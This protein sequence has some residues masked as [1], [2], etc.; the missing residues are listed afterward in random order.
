M[1]VV[2]GCSGSGKSRYL[3]EALLCER[4]ALD[5]HGRHLIVSWICDPQEGQ[6]LPDWQDRVD[7]FA[8]GPVEGL[9]ML[10]DAF[11]R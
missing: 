11:A 9:A 2:V 7:R 3:D 6:S 4:H 10:E 1:E 5:A 8:R